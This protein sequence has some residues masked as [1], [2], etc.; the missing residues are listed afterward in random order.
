[1]NS[2]TRLDNRRSFE[3]VP[4]RSTVRLKPWRESDVNAAYLNDVSW[5]GAKLE[6]PAPLDKGEIVTIQLPKWRFGP[7]RTVSA[8]VVWCTGGKQGWYQIGCRFA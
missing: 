1:M 2:S 3:R 5:K 7:A 4:Q 8:R 6:T